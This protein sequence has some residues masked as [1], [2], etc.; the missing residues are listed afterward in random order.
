MLHTENK[1]APPGLRSMLVDLKRKTFAAAIYLSWVYLHG[2]VDLELQ[3]EPRKDS[4]NI[5]TKRSERCVHK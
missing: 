1:W 5:S 3:R 2:L 4:V